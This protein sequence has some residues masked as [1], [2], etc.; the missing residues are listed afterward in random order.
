MNLSIFITSQNPFVFAGSRAIRNN[1]NYF[2]L[3]QNLGDVGINKMIARQ[4]GLSKIYTEAL[5]KM[6]KYGFVLINRDLSSEGFSMLFSR[7]FE[8]KPLAFLS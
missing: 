8:N 2:L 3:F 1:L 4:M 7:I 6:R 5:S